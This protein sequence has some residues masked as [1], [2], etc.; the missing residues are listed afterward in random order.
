[1]SAEI[2]LKLEGCPGESQATGF[3]EQIDVL[4]FSLGASNPSSVASGGGSGAGKVDVSSLSLQK[5]V[6]KASPKLFEHCCLGTH[7]ATAKLTVRE[8]GGKPLDYYVLDLKEV[9]V[10]NVSVGGASGGGKPSESVS[11]SFAEFK[12]TYQSQDEKGAKKDKV[13]FGFN[14]KKN[15]PA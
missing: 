8:A 11:L 5:I 1:M 6:D 2:F 15:A 12:L 10:D 9:F 13:E 3:E 4:S 14:L 7:V